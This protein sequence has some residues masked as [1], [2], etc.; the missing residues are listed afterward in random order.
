LHRQNA[1]LQ[2][3]SIPI[4]AGIL[5][6]FP[7]YAVFSMAGSKHNYANMLYG[8][9]LIIM[10]RLFLARFILG[11]LLLPSFAWA[12]NEA[13]DSPA[14]QA[15][16]EITAPEQPAKP[17]TPPVNTEK[18]TAAPAKPAIV[19]PAPAKT[20]PA[21]VTPANPASAP[22]PAPKSATAPAKPAPVP[23]PPAK[24]LPPQVAP[25]K[26]APAPA[27]PAKPRAP[28][29]VQ[30]EPQQAESPAEISAQ[31]VD[32]E[33][34]VREGCTN[35]DKASEFLQKLHSL[36][37]HLIINIRDVRKE[38]AALVLLKRMAKN[39][40]ETTL[41][42]PAFVVGG[43]LIMG[44][45]DEANSV[46][47]I[48]DNLPLSHA[49]GQQ[50]DDGTGC[51][52]GKEPGCSLI[53][54]EPAAKPGKININL[55]GHSIP[56]VQIGLPLFTVAMGLLD[57]LNHGSTWA[58]LLMVSLLAPMKK[59]TMMLSIAGTFIAVKGLMYFI[60]MA[61]WLN[62]FVMV[63]I[64]LIMQMAVAG[65][66]LL[67]GAI[68]LKYYIQFD[69]NITLSVHETIKPGIYTRIR[70]IV[71]SESLPAALLGTILLSL[72]VQLGELT[73]TSVFPVLY[74]KILTL[75]QLDQLSNYGYLL[76]YDFAYMLDDI[77]VLGLGIITLN[78]R[79]VT[80]HKG[81]LLKL[82]SALALF[83]VSIYLLLMRY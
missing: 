55:F 17:A 76:L 80:E 67:A 7:V 6:I 48:L 78:N 64:P 36:Q 4:D 38:P 54:R 41:D 34:F 66:A 51:V 46:Q 45:S 72:I 63:D 35:C 79:R 5:N 42:Y 81:R 13:G 75:H 25:T 16:P 37:P 32:I 33:V 62:L 20:P 70:K 14:V 47:Q 30:S 1:T 43:Q 83:G 31:T 69:Q 61:G 2:N 82:C 3:I 65:I 10:T 58:L 11:L 9:I 53:P 56:I 19:A 57:G 21:S 24:Q 39:Q 73:F 60:L 8:D 12:L 49:T 27:A 71:Q 28:D 77:I 52:S 22:A 50:T 23:P 29:P 59:R 40:D 44:F 74:T 26:P 15:A 68:Y 18:Q